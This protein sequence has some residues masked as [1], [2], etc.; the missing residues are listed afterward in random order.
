MQA[1]RAELGIYGVQLEDLFPLLCT[2]FVWESIHLRHGYEGVLYILG[3][4]Q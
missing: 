4:P 2:P 1:W 3:N